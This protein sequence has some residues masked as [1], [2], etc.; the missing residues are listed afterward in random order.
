MRLR[1][2]PALPSLSGCHPVGCLHHV[3]TRYPHAKDITP[4][5]L[6]KGQYT[7]VGALVSALS[8]C[9]LAARPAPSA[10]LV[11]PRTGGLCHKF[12]DKQAV[13]PNKHSPAPCPLLR[14]LQVASNVVL[15]SQYCAV[16]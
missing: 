13:I 11:K 16:K 9:V 14:V 1:R 15:T 12:A 8:T 5:N 2:L 7:C 6:K 4:A 3:P 10:G